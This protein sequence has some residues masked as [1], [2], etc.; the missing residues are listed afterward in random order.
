MS[1]SKPEPVT[2][3]LEG[4]R[5]LFRSAH[6]LE[7]AIES[8]HAPFSLDLIEVLCRAGWKSGIAEALEDWRLTLVI[9]ATA[10]LD[11]AI[12]EEF[13]QGEVRYIVHA[14]K[15]RIRNDHGVTFPPA[16]PPGE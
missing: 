14:V 10:L 6:A 15:E 9:A 3:K 7:D 8:L 4:A 12:H 16:E 1:D 11:D 2:R 5:I 13:E